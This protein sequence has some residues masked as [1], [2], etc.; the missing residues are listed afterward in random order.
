[1]QR[2]PPA[3]T[4]LLVGGPTAVLE[5]AGLRLLTDPT[6]DPPGDHE[7]GLRKLTGPAVGADDVGAIDAVLVSHDQHADNLDPGG[8]A[9]L[10]DAARTLTTTAGAERLGGT[11]IGLEPWASVELERPAGDAVTIT[12]VPALHGPEGSEPITGPVIGFVLQA[13]DAPTLYVSGDNASVDVVRSIAERLGPIEL[14]VLFAGGV[15]LPQR[16][17]GATSRYPRRPPPR[18]PGYSAPAPSCP[19]TSRA[20]R[21]SRRAPTTS[22]RPSR[23][24]ASPSASSCP[25]RARPSAFEHSCRGFAALWARERCAGSYALKARRP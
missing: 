18:P 1:M 24:R 17:D 19:S 15:S 2:M 20:G 7:G 23:R 6:F 9:Y 12:A 16:F 13:S 11:A 3:L 21:T 4:V 25:T 5:Y 22:A 14:A 8:R 10:A